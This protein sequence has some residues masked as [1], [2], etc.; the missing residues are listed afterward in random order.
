M[1]TSC[2][3]IPSEIGVGSVVSS[4]TFIRFRTPGRDRSRGR[5]ASAA[6]RITSATASGLMDPRMSRLGNENPCVQ[7]RR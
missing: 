7:V 2:F 4:P 6:L 3:F 5:R 1:P